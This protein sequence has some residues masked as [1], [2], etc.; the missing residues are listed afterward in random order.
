MTSEKTKIQ[1]LSIK[2]LCAL[3]NI[4]R[5]TFTK[6]LNKKK[7][8]IGERTGGKYTIKQVKIIF[9]EFGSPD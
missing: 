9:E 1:A 2:E 6:W 5:K 4:S 8:E 7:L 3:Y